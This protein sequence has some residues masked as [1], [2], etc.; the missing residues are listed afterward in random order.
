MIEGA[1]PGTMNHADADG[2]PWP[3]SLTERERLLSIGGA[4]LLMVAGVRRSGRSGALLVMA[5]GLLLGRGVTGF[6]PVYAASGRR[7]QP[8]E[9]YEHGQQF[10]AEVLVRATPAACFAFWRELSNH[11]MF[12]PSI[13]SVIEHDQ[14]LSTWTA[15]S[16]GDVL[17]EWTSHVVNEVSDSLLA[18][19]TT[20]SSA[21]PHAGS[22]HFIAVPGTQDTVVKLNVR[23]AAPAGILGRVARRITGDD[24]AARFQEAL[25]NFKQRLEE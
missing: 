3:G 15:R 24:P 10:V 11:P 22:V 12:N 5:G 8:E 7:S 1:R 4:L 20:D 2:S 19:E 6:C 16:R 23:F 9:L 21:F 17:I 14:R 13:V 25:Q 18:W